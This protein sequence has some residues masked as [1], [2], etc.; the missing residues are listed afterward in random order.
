M[1]TPATFAE[2]WAS[3]SADD[4]EAIERSVACAPPIPAESAAVIRRVFAGA[5]ER[6]KAGRQQAA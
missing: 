2:L 5:G 1:T 3:I 4:H 6:I